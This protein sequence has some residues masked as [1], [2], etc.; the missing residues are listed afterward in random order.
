MHG[1]N[2]RRDVS[3]RIAT[4]PTHRKLPVNFRA[5]AAT[6]IDVA[7]NVLGGVAEGTGPIETLR[8]S[9]PSVLRKLCEQMGATYIKVGAS[10]RVSEDGF[11][12]RT[13][14]NSFWLLVPRF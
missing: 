13:C 6:A 2:A 3:A 12:L 9:P 4:S 8:E 5:T 7:F 11:F 1:S 10:A 14:G